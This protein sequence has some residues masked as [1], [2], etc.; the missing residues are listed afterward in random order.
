AMDVKCDME[1]SCPDG[2]TCCRLQSGAWGCCPFTQ[3]VCCEDHIHCC[4][5][6]F[7]CDT[8]KGT[9]EQKLAA[10]LEHHHH[11]H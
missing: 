5:A 4:P 1:V 8:Q 10:A 6:G 11:H 3:A 7:T 2:Y 9:C